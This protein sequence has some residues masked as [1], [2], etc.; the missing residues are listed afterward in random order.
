MI[1]LTVISMKSVIKYLVKVTFV[2][3][4]IVTITRY[5]CNLR[6]HKTE[7]MI[8]S[9]FLKACINQVIP[10][11]NQ[12]NDNIPINGKFYEVAIRSELGVIDSVTNKN[13]QDLNNEEV[14]QTSIPVSEEDENEEIPTNVATQVVE[15]AYHNRYTNE[16]SG[17]QIKNETSYELPNDILNANIKLNKKNVMIFHTHT[18]ESYTPSTDYQYQASGNYRTVDLNYSVARVG[19][20]LTNLLSSVGDRKSTRLNSS[21]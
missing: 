17:V 4:I 14:I 7:K 20:E 19:D 18:C 9:D 15:S 5:F 1:N 6:T 16:Y 2:V 21:H 11:I 12:K 3:I 8:S 13:V 10:L